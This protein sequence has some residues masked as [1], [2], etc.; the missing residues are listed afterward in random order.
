MPYNIILS[1]RFRFQVIDF[2]CFL[3]FICL[4]QRPPPEIKKKKSMY[5]ILVHIVLCKLY[6]CGKKKKKK[7]LFVQDSSQ[8]SCVGPP[9]S[10][11][12]TSVAMVKSIKSTKIILSNIQC[13]KCIIDFLSTEMLLVVT[14]TSKPINNKTNCF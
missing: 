2:Q 6:W 7:V 11:L 5:L 12:N 13:L 4:W 1:F 8:T 14:Q 3:N 10:L 9:R